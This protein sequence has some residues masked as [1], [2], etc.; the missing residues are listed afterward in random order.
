MCYTVV[1]D[2]FNKELKHLINI[3]SREGK[4]NTPDYILAMYLERCLETFEIAVTRRDI[5][6]G[7]VTTPP[8]VD[9]PGAP[10]PENH[11]GHGHLEHLHPDLLTM[12]TPK[13]SRDEL[14]ETVPPPVKTFLRSVCGVEGHEPECEIDLD[15]NWHPCTCGKG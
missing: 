14:Y 11:P 1:M 15:V 9:G 4:S 13:E 6:E 5:H 7:R 8:G 10:V 12:C 3:H 2:S